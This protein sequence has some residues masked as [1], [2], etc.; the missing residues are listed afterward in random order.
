MYT[1][2]YK[3]RT[4]HLATKFV[5]R[6]KKKLWPHLSH[7]TV[8]RRPSPVANPV[9]ASVYDGLRSKCVSDYVANFSENNCEFPCSAFPAFWLSGICENLYTE[10]TLRQ[11]RLERSRHR[12]EQNSFGISTVTSLHLALVLCTPLN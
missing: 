10:I 12:V 6:G 7:K 1:V 11:G 9:F 5:I 4:E 8:H 2:A 3:G